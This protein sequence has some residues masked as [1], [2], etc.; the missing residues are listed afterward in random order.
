MCHFA[1][2]SA[3]TSG[4]GSAFEASREEE[5]STFKEGEAH[6]RLNSRM[7]ACL[8][9]HLPR[10]CCHF[11]ILPH[12]GLCGGDAAAVS[13]A[14]AAAKLQSL[15][16]KAARFIVDSPSNSVSVERQAQWFLHRQ[17]EYLACQSQFI[18]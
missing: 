4:C 6:G 1:H 16:L 13:P 2:D 12:A 8:E 15:M 9:D 14:Y 10:H 18:S 17:F 11:L 7:A 5:K 3:L